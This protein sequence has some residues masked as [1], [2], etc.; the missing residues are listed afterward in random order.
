L[1][2]T[3]RSAE[4]GECD[5]QRA[6]RRSST[7]FNILAPSDAEKIDNCEQAIELNRAQEFALKL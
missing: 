4:R 6:G 2:R 7:I 1:I 3:T 5:E